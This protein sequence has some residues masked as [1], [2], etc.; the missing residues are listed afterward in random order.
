[1]A[2]LAWGEREDGSD[3]VPDADEEEMHIFMEARRHLRPSVFDPE[4]WQ[5]IA[6]D[7]YPKIVYVLNRG[8]R[9]QNYSGGYR[10]TANGVQLGNRYGK[11]ATAPC[12]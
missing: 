11:L 8:G 3:S 7:L 5:A 10:E 1:M 9:F 2:D 12:V 4:R 6:D